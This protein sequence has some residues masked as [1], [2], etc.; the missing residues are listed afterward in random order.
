MKAKS[1]LFVFAVIICVSRFLSVNVIQAKDGAQKTDPYTGIAFEKNSSVESK[2]PTQPT[3][4]SCIH[5]LWDVTHGNPFGYD[6]YN[7]Y[8][9]LR[10]MLQDLG[11][12]VTMTS[13]LMGANLQENYDILVVNLASSH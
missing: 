5:L 13:N 6:P 1:Y 12:S 2:N 8:S 4:P 10:W 11:I 3:A 9:T 7:K